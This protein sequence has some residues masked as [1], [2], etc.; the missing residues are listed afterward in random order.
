M[1]E[2][3]TDILW[4]IFSYIGVHWRTMSSCT[5][6]ESQFQ[7]VIRWQIQL[8]SKYQGYYLEAITEYKKLLKQHDGDSQAA[9]QALFEENRLPT[10]PATSPEPKHPHIA[11]FVL[12]EFM[13]W[14]VAF[15]GFRTFGYENYNGWMGGGSFLSQPPPYRALPNDVDMKG[16]SHE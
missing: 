12:L 2:V 6:P 3:D 15:G 11:D 5:M 13:R 4:K 7:E 9:L 1:S 14:N 8:D 10:P 16:A